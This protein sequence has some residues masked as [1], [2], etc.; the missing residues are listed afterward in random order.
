MVKLI[1][2]VQPEVF[3]SALRNFFTESKIHK[4]TTKTPWK[5]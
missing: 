4:Y 1:Y 2:I 5:S 3:Y